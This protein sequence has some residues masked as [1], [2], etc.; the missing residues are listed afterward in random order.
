MREAMGSKLN[1]PV[2]V[3]RRRILGWILA[4]GALVPMLR[5][6]AQPAPADAALG[7]DI[8]EWTSAPSR[9][10]PA[11]VNGHTVNLPIATDLHADGER[12][13]RERIPILLFFDL[14]DCPYCDRALHEF[15][16]P[17]ANGS[18]WG[19]RAIY[20]QIEIDKTDA[21]TDFNGDKTTYRAVAQRFKVKVTPTIHVVDAKGVTLG[22]PLVGLMTPDFYGGYLEQAINEATARLKAAA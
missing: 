8:D 6:T 17:M 7:T 20:R 3:L 5:A 1:G 10:R 2:R 18:E 4:S 12:C 22:K 11:R 19:S 13:A 15:L 14:W 9:E 21:L 16:V